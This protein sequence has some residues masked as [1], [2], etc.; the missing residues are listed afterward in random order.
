MNINLRRILRKTFLIAVVFSSI[1]AVNSSSVK[2]ETYT[3]LL[4]N[5]T[6]YLCSDHKITKDTIEF[7]MNTDSNIFSEDDWPSDGSLGTITVT[8]S[9]YKEAKGY[10]GKVG[11][12]K[13]KYVVKITM[14]DVQ[15]GQ[16][17]PYLKIEADEKDGYYYPDGF[18]W[19]YD[20]GV[21]N[22]CNKNAHK[23]N[24]LAPKEESKGSY[25][26]L[27][28]GYEFS[29]DS[30]VCNF[31]PYTY[32][33]KYYMSN[34]KLGNPDDTDPTP[35]VNPKDKNGNYMIQDKYGKTGLAYGH[36]HTIAKA[37]PTRKGYDFAGWKCVRSDGK[38]DSKIYNAGASYN[39]GDW[40]MTNSRKTDNLWVY[41]YATWTPKPYKVAFQPN[42][43]SNA[44]NDVKGRMEPITC[45]VGKGIQ[46][47]DNKYS[48]TGWT[49]TGWNTK[50]DG[51]GDSYTNSQIVT[52]LTCRRINENVSIFS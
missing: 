15:V 22:G 39:P 26:F 28:V 31:K 32:G 52:N 37:L 45:I 5:K 41:F 42:K 2:A 4:K 13:W 18:D 51:S 14:K 50:A 34:P 29:A 49:F 38:T 19:I 16:H 40:I 48:L 36:S 10:D 44:S 33:I 3:K 25:L 17:T 35:G 1:L 47:P 20:D 11:S 12:H 21:S 9:S 7:K 24:N 43:P 8:N 46:L 6:F 30:I 27:Y 23:V